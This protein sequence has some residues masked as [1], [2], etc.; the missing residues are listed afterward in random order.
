MQKPPQTNH[1][2]E[3]VPSTTFISKFQK[4]FDHLYKKMK[5]SLLKIKI[6][7]AS[8]ASFILCACF[9]SYRKD[10]LEKNKC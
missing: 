3:N 8:V 7:Q 10:E 4:A 5:P 1:P 2:T 9:S 6:V